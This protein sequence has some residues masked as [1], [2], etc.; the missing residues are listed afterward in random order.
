[1]F[2]HIFTLM[3][4]VYAVTISDITPN[5][6]EMVSEAFMHGNGI[7]MSLEYHSGYLPLSK[8]ETL[9]ITVVPHE[10]IKMHNQTCVMSGI[11]DTVDREKSGNERV[12]VSLGGLMFEYYGE[13]GEIREN[14]KIFIGVR[15]V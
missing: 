14:D 13:V 15:R 3:S 4:T 9:E 5:K 8:G 6:H 10:I 2:L 1:M 12:V 11:V 7:K